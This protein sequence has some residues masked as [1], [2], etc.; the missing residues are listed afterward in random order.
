[1]VAVLN[2]FKRLADSGTAIFQ[3]RDLCFGSFVELPALYGFAENDLDICIND[4][5]M[6][7]QMWPKLHN[8]SYFDFSGTLTSKTTNFRR[9]DFRYFSHV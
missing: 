1:M 6:A 3:H 2:F 4:R 5:A 8:F 7:R 9:I